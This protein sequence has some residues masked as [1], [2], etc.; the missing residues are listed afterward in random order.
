MDQKTNKSAGGIVTNI[1]LGGITIFLIAMFI[2]GAVNKPPNEHIA[3]GQPWN[4]NMVKGDENA[5][6]K[7][8]QYTDYFC[9]FCA[10]VR[11]AVEDPRFEAQ[12]I[13]SGKV[14]YETRI[15][16]VLKDVS[17]NTEQGAEAAFCSADQAKY[18]EYSSHIVDRIKTDFFDKGIGVKN[19]ANPVEISKLPLGYFSTSA[20]AVGMDVAKFES[21]MTSESHK[22]EIAENT[23]KSIRLGVTGLPYL[24]VN[25][26][27]TSGFRGG[28]SGLETVLKAGDVNWI[29]ILL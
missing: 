1:I 20:Q 5:P 25:D 10:E 15:V 11:E 22:S 29:K 23:S 13:D 17:P 7:F 8:I 9:S 3:D 4:T 14:R 18:W 16:T 2:Y 6:N 12:Y 19:V 26:Y 21:C 27:S 24:V 28:Y